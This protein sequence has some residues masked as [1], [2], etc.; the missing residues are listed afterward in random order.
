MGAKKKKFNSVAV[1][2]ELIRKKTFNGNSFS[3]IVKDLNG[4]WSGSVPEWLCTNI[5]KLNDG[6]Y[7]IFVREDHKFISK[8]KVLTPDERE[9]L[10]EL[11]S[12]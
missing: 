10:K 11:Q 4:P 12:A 7:I 5:T 1:H 8:M 9:H 2:V 3:Y 6:T